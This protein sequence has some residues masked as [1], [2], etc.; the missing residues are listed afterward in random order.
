MNRTPNTWR[1]APPV[2]QPEPLV[3]D[4]EGAARALGVG[5][6]TI[7]E[8]TRRGDLP[9][10][11]IGRRRLYRLDDLRAFVARLAR[12]GGAA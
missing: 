8:L 9:S 5:L 1:A 11:T 3:T 6:T 10:I 7:R 12:E 4:T 2:A